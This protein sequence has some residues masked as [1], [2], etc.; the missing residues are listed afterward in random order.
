[1]SFSK[2]R[3]FQKIPHVSKNS[4]S[5]KLRLF[6]N[7]VFFKKFR[8]FQNY[9]FFKMTSFS[10]IR[11]FQN[12]VFSKFRVFQKNSA[13]FKKFPVFQNDVFFKNTC[14]SKLR[15]FK[16]KKTR[17]LTQNTIHR[18]KHLFFPNAFWYICHSLPLSTSKTCPNIC[19]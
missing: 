4:R 3:L 8:T 12:Y 17:L 7:S 18:H 1:M 10:K 9:V 13:R 6:Q 5:K 2:L 16:K 19:F 15:F 14:F 11:L